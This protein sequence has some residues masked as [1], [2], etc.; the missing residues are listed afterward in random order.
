MAKKKL[1]QAGQEPVEAVESGRTC[2]DKGHDN[3]SLPG[4]KDIMQKICHKFG[5]SLGKQVIP[6]DFNADLERP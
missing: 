1:P 4:G 6:R 3:R 5:V 2:P